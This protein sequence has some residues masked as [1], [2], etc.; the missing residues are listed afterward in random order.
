MRFASHQPGPPLED[1]V[2][3]F[4]HCSH[5]AAHPRARILPCGTCELVVN[6][7]DD[8][9]RIYDSQRPE[10]YERFPGI[11]VV[12]AYAGAFDIDPSQR[13]FM[14]GVHF[15]PGGAFPF[16]GA[17]VGELV[18]SHVALEDLWGRPATELRERLCAAATPQKR[19]QILEETLKDRLRCSSKHPAVSLALDIFGAAGIGDSVRA[20]A[21]RVG[22][23]QRRFIQLFTGQVGL[24]PKLFCRVLRFKHAREFVDQARAL[25]WSQVALTCG[26]SD[27]SHLIHDFLEFSGQSPTGYLCQGSNNLLLNVASAP[28]FGRHSRLVRTHIRLLS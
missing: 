16:F 13:T 12:G 18:S 20:V 23:C 9:I 17:A 3:T 6:L 4:W 28:D 27:Q 26:Y 5:A 19:F 21:E 1:F 24:T 15:K 11:V 22:L 2:H 14:M 8:E 25:D 10:C 7:R